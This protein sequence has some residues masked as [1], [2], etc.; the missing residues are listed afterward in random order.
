LS[1]CFEFLFEGQISDQDIS[2]A[3]SKLLKKGAETNHFLAEEGRIALEKLC[4]FTHFDKSIRFLFPY[5]E[6]KSHVTRR[7]ISHCLVLMMDLV[8]APNIEE[9][10]KTQ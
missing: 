6:E 10:P 2:A 3:F 4:K 8:G 7:Q 5:Y 9:V 1:D